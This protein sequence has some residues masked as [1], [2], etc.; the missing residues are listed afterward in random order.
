LFWTRSGMPMFLLLAAAACSEYR[1]KPDDTPHGDTDPPDTNVTETDTDVPVAECV[2]SDVPPIEV[3]FDESCGATVG[4]FEPVVEWEELGDGGSLSIPIIAD[5]DGDGL[6]EITIGLCD[7]VAWT[8]CTLRS[9]HGDGSGLYA[10]SDVQIGYG[11]G[12]AVADLDGDG[13][14]E[15]VTVETDDERFRV[16]ALDDTLVRKWTSTWFFDGEMDY[17]SYPA[18]SDMDHDGSP[19]IV[20]G[21]VILNADG[22]TRGVG[23]LGRGGS[24]LSTG[25]TEDTNSFPMDVDLDGVEEV[26]AGNALYTPDGE[27]KA[28]AAIPDGLPAVGNFDDDP[29]A[30]ILVA[31]HRSLYL[32]DTDMTVKWGPIEF[33]DANIIGPPAVADLDGDGKTDF[34]AAIGAHLRAFDRNATELWSVATEDSSGATGPSLFDFDGDGVPEV[35]YADEVDVFAVDGKTGV[36]KFRSNEHDSPTMY[37][38]PTI[39]D[40]DDDGH[41]EVVVSHQGFDVGMSG[42][43]VYGD[44]A[45]SWMDTRKVWNQHAFSNNNIDDALGVPKKPTP[46][47]TEQD[48]FRAA[49]I[50]G[51]TGVNVRPSFVE[52]CTDDCDTGT[53]MVTVRVDN[54]G[55]EV[56][57]AGLK[58]S[59]Y[60]N[61]TA[62]EYLIGTATTTHPIDPGWSSPGLVFEFDTTFL[63]GGVEGLWVIADDDGYSEGVI[64]ECHEDDN[65]ALWK[66]DNDD[67]R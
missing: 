11:T 32:L 22:T 56:V 12:S 42:F 7:P 6:P 31:S 14:P 41:A 54:T 16:V 28:S 8:I 9:Y 15:V 65:K 20:V 27:V 36:V 50:L 58:V 39:A 62:G 10:A 24:E 53:M 33:S 61:K 67:C 13:R 25:Y 4:A 64:D 45:N 57:P 26:V 3:G 29:E 51:G 63:D 18:I 30:E 52:V 43:S 34:V 5:L 66:L 40:V 19:E 1:L 17:S 59:L 21:R 60:A 46:A 44:A 38:V 23:K 37:D 55:G 35:V 48:T 49:R 2:A 47:F